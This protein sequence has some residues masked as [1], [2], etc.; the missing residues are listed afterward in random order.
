MSDDLKEHL[1]TDTSDRRRDSAYSKCA[2]LGLDGKIA[3]VYYLPP[4]ECI[5]QIK[6]M[7]SNA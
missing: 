4:P 3:G 1:T 5:E 7:M 2:I 6:K